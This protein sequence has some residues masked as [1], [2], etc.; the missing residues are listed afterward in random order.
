M[1]RNVSVVNCCSY[2][3]QCMITEKKDTCYASHFSIPVKGN[4]MNYNQPNQIQNSSNVYF[5]PTLHGVQ[6]F[7]W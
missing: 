6:Y 4:P 3:G 7:Y 2:Q 1:V 5:K